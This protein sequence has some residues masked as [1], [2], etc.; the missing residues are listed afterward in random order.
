MFS[1][2]NNPFAGTQSSLPFHPADASG[3]RRA[4]ISGFHREH[5]THPKGN[6]LLNAFIESPLNPGPEIDAF[7]SNLARLMP[8][9]PEVPEAPFH[10][11][12]A[13][14][15]AC[16]EALP[17][18]AYFSGKRSGPVHLTGMD[19]RTSAIERAHRR[20]EETA[21]LLGAHPSTTTMTSH[22]RSADLSKPDA[23]AAIPL[24]SAD[25]LFVRHQNL[26]NG[27]IKW[28]DILRMAISRLRPEG[29]ILITSYFDQE[30]IMATRLLLDLGAEIVATAAN[31]ESFPLGIPGKAIDRQWARFSVSSLPREDGIVSRPPEIRLW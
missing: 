19:V 4:I 28:T 3:V 16:V 29:T 26:W 21:R 18:A 20:W 14:C 31:P 22:F 17:L 1:T 2:Q 25:L 13:A 23:W 7:W 6:P 12:N 11:I 15:G 30:H 10:I 5:G 27:L 9:Q 24:A 8:E